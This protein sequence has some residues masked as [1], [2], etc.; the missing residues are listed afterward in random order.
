MG[1]ARKG[2]GTMVSLGARMCVALAVSMMPAVLLA[3]RPAAADPPPVPANSICRKFNSTNSLSAQ[4]SRIGV[5][6][7]DPYYPTQFVFDFGGLPATYLYALD[8]SNNEY[9]LADLRAGKLTSSLS[10]FSGMEVCVVDPG[11]VLPPFTSRYS[12]GRSAVPGF[13]RSEG[14]D[15]GAAVLGGVGED[16]VADRWVVRGERGGTAGSV[17]AVVQG[18]LP[19]LA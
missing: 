19:A 6:M 16:R 10:S 11:P 12:L 3:Q 5:T 4:D 15:G 9:S 13:P 7:N 17:G 18:V 8:G 14:D 1:G 2:M